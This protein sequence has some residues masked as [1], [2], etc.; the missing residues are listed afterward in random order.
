MIKE[1]FNFIFSNVFVFHAYLE[2]DF[3]QFK[4]SKKLIQVTI[5]AYILVNC[6]YQCYNFVI[7]KPIFNFF[8]P[9]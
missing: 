8:N 7:I 3:L 4:T 1:Y 5:Y 2:K 6:F 9:S